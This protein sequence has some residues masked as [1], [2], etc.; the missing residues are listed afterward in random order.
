L[1]RIIRKQSEEI[2]LPRN[3]IVGPKKVMAVFLAI[4]ITLIIL[5]FKYDLYI[6]ESGNVEGWTVLSI[7]SLYL[8][9]KV[10][11]SLTYKPV[12]RKRTPRRFPDKTVSVVVPSYN[13]N[14]QSV[15]K[16]VK[17][18]LSQTV[19]IKE[20]IFV[21]DG[22]EDESAYL[23]MLDL[24]RRNNR[25][26]PTKII[27]HRFEENKG[28]KAAQ[29][30]GFTKATGDLFLLADSDG[31]LLPNAVEELMKPFRDET[32]GSVNGFIGVL[33]AKKN[34]L[35]R[36][37]EMTYVS[38]FSMGRASQ[39][40][41]NSVVVCS[42]ALSMHRA[43]VVKENIEEFK[44]TKIMGINMSSGDDRMLTSFASRSGWKTK[45]QA[46][47]ICYTEVPETLGK[48]LRQRTRW[49]RSAYICSL[50]NMLQKPH[51]NFMYNLLSFL[52]TY[53]WLITSILWLIFSQ[54]IHFNLDFIEHVV[55]F[56]ILTCYL[57]QIY[58]F[59]HSP[60]RFLFSPI[61][62]FAYSL[63]LYYTRFTTFF[64]LRRDGWR[65]R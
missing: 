33:N 7:S 28:K 54:S 32:I 60:I 14:A 46:T 47:A 43:E 44:K 15:V 50:D 59:F 53:I 9:Y 8:F 30:W 42:G 65:T 45:Y 26:G 55:V 2:N 24:Q 41:F 18:L 35:T 40:V 11:S 64:L 49:M 25:K 1:E 21:D 10:F 19:E 52:E 62:S 17:S 29:V 36:M 5:A 13:E 39:S 3:V 6:L 61:Y 51:R 34:F 38:A 27:V 4:I 37:Q 63:T 48:Y 22:S 20:I 23:A 58:Y 12:L 57:S 16:S 31:Q 56:W